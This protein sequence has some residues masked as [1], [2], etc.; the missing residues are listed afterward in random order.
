[1]SKYNEDF[2]GKQGSAAKAMASMQRTYGKKKGKSVF[3]GTKNKH[4][5]GESA[6]MKKAEIGC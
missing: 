6:S 5:K 3:Y 4:E 2:G 1:M